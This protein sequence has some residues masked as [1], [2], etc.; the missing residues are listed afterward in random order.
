MKKTILILLIFTMT[1]ANAF[2]G[3]AS[4]DLEIDAVRDDGAVENSETENSTAEDTLLNKISEVNSMQD[5]EQ[6]IKLWA[7][8]NSTENYVIINK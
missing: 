5:D 7:K 1:A 4:D 3:T 8:F 6:K 2:S